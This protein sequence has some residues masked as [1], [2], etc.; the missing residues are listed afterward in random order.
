MC[1]LRRRQLFQL[2]DSDRH[3]LAYAG[4]RGGERRACGCASP[5]RTGL[6]NTDTRGSAIQGDGSEIATSAQGSPRITNEDI[7][8]AAARFTTRPPETLSDRTFQSH[9]AE[10]VDQSKRIVPFGEL[11]SI[12]RA[13]DEVDACTFQRVANLHDSA[14]VSFN[15]AFGGFK[16][17]DSRYRHSSPFT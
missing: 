5:R 12:I 15:E 14:V 11:N 10:A 3:A 13:I 9:A 7:E 17:P 8:I 1:G 2:L 16:T 6:R 4:T